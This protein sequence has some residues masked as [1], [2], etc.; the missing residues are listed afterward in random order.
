M[1]VTGF[2]HGPE[3]PQSPRANC[4]WPAASWELFILALSAPFC[5]CLSFCS[6]LPCLSCSLFSSILPN[7][8]YFQLGKDVLVFSK[9]KP[10]TGDPWNH[11]FSLFPQTGNILAPL[12]GNKAKRQA[13][14]MLL[15]VMM[16]R[17]EGVFKKKTAENQDVLLVVHVCKRESERGR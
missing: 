12:R 2:C 10:L 3:R 6:L 8:V 17:A 16:I 7:G 4:F 1:C 14:Q 15:C 9:T 11:I 5:L 13:N